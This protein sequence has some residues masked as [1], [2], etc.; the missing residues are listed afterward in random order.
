MKKLS[1]ISLSKIYKNEMEKRELNQ[2]VGGVNC[3]ICG[4]DQESGV[5]SNGNANK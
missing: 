4:C 2:V 5:L 1:K 3:C